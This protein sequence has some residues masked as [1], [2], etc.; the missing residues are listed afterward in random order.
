MR[1]YLRIKAGRTA[2][3]ALQ[4]DPRPRAA[5]AGRAPNAWALPG[6]GRG[7]AAR[8]WPEL[9]APSFHQGHGPLRPAWTLWAWADPPAAWAGLGEAART[10]RDGEG[11]GVWCWETLKTGRLPPARFPTVFNAPVQVFNA[12]SLWTRRL[13]DSEAFPGCDSQGVFCDGVM[14]SR[15]QRLS[16]GACARDLG[17]PAAGPGPWGPRDRGRFSSVALDAPKGPGECA[18]A[19]RCLCVPGWEVGVLAILSASC[20]SWSP[21]LLPLRHRLLA[22][23]EG[24]LFGAHGGGWGGRGVGRM[25]VG[26][27]SPGSECRTGS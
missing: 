17:R 16:L 15:D 27:G 8:A 12:P 2:R 19:P 9:R 13:G 20:P 23:P 10:W 7:P 1:L 14:G 26:T 5:Q 22:H 6:L 11:G 4:R 21:C 18:E 24:V 3:L 25:Q